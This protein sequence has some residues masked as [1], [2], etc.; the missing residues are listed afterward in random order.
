MFCRCDY[1]E[2]ILKET[3]RKESYH[4]VDITTPCHTQINMVFCM[5]DKGHENISDVCQPL[6]NKDIN[7][8]HYIL[9]L[10]VF[11]FEWH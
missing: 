3:S 6:K 7:L 11:F 2:K 9:W 4:D 8:Y 1:V 10:N 5:H